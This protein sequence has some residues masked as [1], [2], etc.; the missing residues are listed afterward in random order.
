M[1]E[2]RIT[3][4]TCPSCG[5]QVRIPE[6][7]TRFTCGYCGTEHLVEGLSRAGEPRPVLRKRVPKPA[8]VKVANDG[9]SL[10]I[11]QRWYSWKYLSA[12]FFCIFWDGFLVIWYVIAFSSNAPLPF[13]LFP[14]VHVTVGVVVT[15]TTI[16]GLV[17][18]T[19]VELTRDELSV[20]Y[21][22]LLWPGEKKLKTS[23]IRQLFCKEVVSRSRNSTSISYDLYAI[24]QD[25]RQVK[26]ATKLESRDV[27][28]FF[29]Q[30]IET[31]LLIADRPV[32]GELERAG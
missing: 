16:A 3:P 17:N 12:L 25:E 10:S 13:K 27:A 8:S 30:Q 31:W 29:E 7:A 22:P 26:F 28:L 20:W 4:L 5:A 19:T 2:I 24:D 32:E 6:N 14:L 18:R 15:Y 23:Q 9:E 11:S 21:E 1:S